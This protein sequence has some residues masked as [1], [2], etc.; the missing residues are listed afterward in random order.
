MP[1]SIR[2]PCKKSKNLISAQSACS[3]NY[4]T[5]NAI[6]KFQQFLSVTSY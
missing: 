4:G 5:L 1:S 3:D 2:R 6:K